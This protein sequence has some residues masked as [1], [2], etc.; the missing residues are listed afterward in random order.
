MSATVTT[1]AWLT[2][3]LDADGY[4]HRPVI[5]RHLDDINKNVNGGLTGALH[6]IGQRGWTA[7]RVD[8]HIVVLKTNRIRLLTDSIE[9]LR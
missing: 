8:N 7:I 9:I 1:N 3:W 4:P 6:E 2:Q 5:L